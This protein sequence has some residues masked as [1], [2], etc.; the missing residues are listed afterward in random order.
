MSRPLRIDYPGA[1][2]H[3]MNRARRNHDLYQNVED[4]ELF[5]SLLQEAAALFH[6]NIAAYCLMPDHYHLLVQSEDGNLSRCMRHINGIYTQKYNIRHKADGTLFRGRYKSVLVQE[7]SYLLQLI[8]Y[9]HKNS[10]KAGLAENPGDY[11]WSSHAGYG[12]NKREWGWIYKDFI[13]S[14]LT[15]QKE[16][17]GRQYKSFMGLPVTEEIESF[18]S[19]KHL[20]SILGG[21]AF[22]AWVKKTFFT[23]KLNFEVP[24]SKRLAPDTDY[25]NK[26]VAESYGIESDQLFTAKRGVENEPRN[27]AI[28]ISRHLKGDP[29][30]KIGRVFNLKRD[31][32]VSSAIERVNKKLEKDKKLRER[33]REIEENLYK[34]QTETLYF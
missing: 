11:K 19:G 24:E 23:E 12:S 18:Y 20:P 15:P 14:M 28:Y 3:V 21:T 5:L 13:L 30:N 33:V 9:I 31:S 34:G 8:R 22:A 29:L 26:V 32:S 6:M 10:V 1:W 7:D 16:E 2:H 17:Q 4:Y 27:V 25:I